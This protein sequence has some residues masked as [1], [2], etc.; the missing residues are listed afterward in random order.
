MVVK[1]E[2]LSPRAMVVNP[3]YTS[4]QEKSLGIT[5][6][7]S[8]NGTLGPQWLYLRFDWTR[9][10]PVGYHLVLLCTHC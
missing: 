4:N 2:E 5:R 6:K 10:T 9:Y 8:E 1:D 3:S 7:Q